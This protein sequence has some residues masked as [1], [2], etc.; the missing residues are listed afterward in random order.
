MTGVGGR[1][2]STPLILLCL[3]FSP[4]SVLSRD[5][6]NTGFPVYENDI[7]VKVCRRPGQTKCVVSWMT[8]GTGGDETIMLD[9][10]SKNSADEMRVCVNPLSWRAD[11]VLVHREQNPGS[12]AMVPPRQFLNI[13]YNG[14]ST[15]SYSA[16]AERALFPEHGGMCSLVSSS[17]RM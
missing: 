7:G 2:M 11:E 16:V 15:T 17:T 9:F 13:L 3:L 6:T 4:S 14:L 12:L 5:N 8:Y 1:E 10:A